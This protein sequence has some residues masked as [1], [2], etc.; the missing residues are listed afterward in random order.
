MAQDRAGADEFGTRRNVMLAPHGFGRAAKRR[1]HFGFAG[2]EFVEQAGRERPVAGLEPNPIAA[3]E[4]D[5]GARAAKLGDELMN[6]GQVGLQSVVTVP[7]G[8]RRSASIGGRASLICLV[9][10]VQR[11]SRRYPSAP[12]PGSLASPED[13]SLTPSGASWYKTSTMTVARRALA[14]LGLL[15]LLPSGERL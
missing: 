8:G 15:A 10:A 3:A 1:N 4:F 7:G 2:F 6:I 14:L 13:G 5:V 9:Y 12:G 11:K